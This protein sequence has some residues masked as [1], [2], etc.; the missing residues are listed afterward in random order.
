MEELRAKRAECQVVEVGLSYLRRLAQGRLDIVAAE[1]ARRA[2]GGPAPDPD[3]LVRSL[4]GILSDHLKAPGNGR[5]PQLLGPDLN[6]LDTTRLDGIAGPGR[7][8]VI[9][10]ASDDLLAQLVDQL[11]TYETEISASRRALHERIDALQAEL[12]RRYKTGEASVETLL[13]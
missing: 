1:V 11:S 10:D 8:V 12:T 13:K 6:E 7:L 4:S 2:E 5:L 3:Q 9:A